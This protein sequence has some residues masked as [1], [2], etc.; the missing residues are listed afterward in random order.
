MSIKFTTIPQKRLIQGITSSSSSF[1][2]NNILSFDGVN[3][4]TPADLGTIH[5]C[6]FRNDT[7]TVLEL[8]EIDPA[9]LISGGAIT[10][11][12]RGLSFY[13]DLTTETTA[14]KLD[15][16][17]NTI[18][19]LGTDVPQI[20]QWL[21]EYI[22]AAA[23]A[24][25]VPASTSAAGIVVEGSQAEVDAGT[26]TKTISAVAYKLFAP[27]DKIRGKLFNDYAVDSVGTD[28]YAITITPAITDYTAGQVFTF[29]A[30]TANTGAATLNVS[31]LGAK[32]ITKN[33]N[34][35]LSTGDIQANQLVMVQYDGTQM[36]LL[37]NKMV[38]LT[39]DV[40]GI[41]PD[42]NGG[43]GGGSGVVGVLRNSIVKTYFNVQLL[44]IL[45]TGDALNAASTD[46]PN[47]IRNSSDVL[48]A[49]AGISAEF[50][51]AGADSIYLNSIFGS[52][53]SATIQ[54]DNTN[55][56]ILD[57][58]AKLPATSTGD[59][60]MGFANNS[61]V[62][63][64]VYNSSTNGFVGFSMRG[65]TGVIYATISKNAVGVTNTDVSSGIT[66]TNWNNFRIE[67]DIS[68]NALFYI[69]G[70][71]KATLSGANLTTSANN[72]LFGF[73]RSDSADFVLTAPTLSLQMNP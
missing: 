33:Y 19:M 54:F 63:N 30:G 52:G 51:S 66:N 2:L 71:L 57:W 22:D 7:G 29:K 28:A 6:A 12:R 64:R 73:G 62:Y 36:Q 9:T 24:G 35:A 53:T 41:L 59:I 5:Y 38:D 14:L 45:W 58:W 27:L 50:Q 37:S 31:G 21:K 4:I 10:I 15:W 44:F 42:T 43:L 47:W 39:T 67:F 68:N 1:Y 65:S 20:F 17:T 18:V 13:G 40:Y 25:A 8:M 69:N 72:I 32:A 49:P 60:N 34:V 11:T 61:A 46:F 23:I 70:V 55:I 56:L 26:A 48:V 16:P 3:D